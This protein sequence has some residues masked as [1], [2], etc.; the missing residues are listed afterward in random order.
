VGSRL[1]LR[2]GTRASALARAQTDLVAGTLRDRH[3]G[4]EV[5]VVLISTSGDR[6]QHTNA[7]SADWGSGV[8]VKELEAALVLGSI[9]LAVHSLKDVPPRPTPGLDLVAIPS[10]EDPRD[11]LVTPDARP[12]EALPHGARVG[13]S[14]ARRVAFLRAIRPDLEFA[15]IRGNVDTRLRKLMS[16]EY[17]AIL[18]ARAG[19]RRLG[20]G[21]STAD[22]PHVVLEPDVLPPA[23]GQGALGLQARS[24]DEWVA[25]LLE[26]LD[27]PATAAAVAAE[28][29]LMARLEGGCRLPIGALATPDEAE[30]LTLRAA[31]ADADGRRVLR[32][33]GVGHLDSPEALADEVADRLLAAGAADLLGAAAV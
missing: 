18:L 21:L 13:T 3:P 2:L 11:V 23:P 30:R 8:F 22:V 5:E 14:S 15:P 28:R 4:L 33:R 7:P 27:D 26:P 32:D 1:V 25:S 19:L 29:R 24:N 31:I 10:R 6:S 16:G 20:F 12:L 9:D 17:D